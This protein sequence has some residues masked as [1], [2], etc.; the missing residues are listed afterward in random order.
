MGTTSFSDTFHIFNFDKCAR[1]Y[2]GCFC[3]RFKRRLSMSGMTERIANAD[4]CM[5]LTE[6]DLSRGGSWTIKLP[7]V[8][9]NTC[10]DHHSL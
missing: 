2:L 6:R 8:L 3:F 7:D 4:C 9:A 10:L 1:R 5:P